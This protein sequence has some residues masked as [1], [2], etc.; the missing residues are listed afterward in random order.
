MAYF[1]CINSI[2]WI[3][4]NVYK[5]EKIDNK[6]L[7]SDYK[8]PPHYFQETKEIKDISDL[9]KDRK[10]N[11]YTIFF[12]ERY[13]KRIE[14]MGKQYKEP[15]IN[16]KNYRETHCRKCKEDINNEFF[17]ECNYCKWI[18]CNCWACLC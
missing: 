1:K 11:S 18:I 7:I 10:S 4:G 2:A 15:N 8:F 9:K 12:I 13:K 3:I 14:W 5:W 6:I 17:K 16:E